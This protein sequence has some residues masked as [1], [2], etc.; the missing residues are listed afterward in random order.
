MHPETRV[1]YMSG[2]A[3]DLGTGSVDS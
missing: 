3:D 1:L 2:Y